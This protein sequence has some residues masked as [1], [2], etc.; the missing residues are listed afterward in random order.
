MLEL[1]LTTAFL[2]ISGYAPRR[3]GLWRCWSQHWLLL[4]VALFRSPLHF[5][6]NV[7]AVDFFELALQTTAATANEFAAVY[8]RLV[9]VPNLNEDCGARGC[10]GDNVPLVIIAE[11]YNVH[12]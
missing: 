2:P 9:R 12:S 11:P 3:Q 7:T 10:G 1:L 8:G 5:P 6:L 4:L